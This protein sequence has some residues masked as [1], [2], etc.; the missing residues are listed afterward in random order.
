VIAAR[1]EPHAEH[2]VASDRVR[3]AGPTYG[4][5]SLDFRDARDIEGARRHPDGTHDFLHE[6]VLRGALERL[7]ATAWRE[8]SEG[9]GSSPSERC[10]VLSRV[11]N[12]ELSRP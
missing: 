11:S 4:R 12:S 5:R 6:V 3:S 2:I 7:D 9:C 8:G 1:A 10:R